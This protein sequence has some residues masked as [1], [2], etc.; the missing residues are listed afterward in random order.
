MQANISSHLCFFQISDLTLTNPLSSDG[1]C[2]SIVGFQ[3]RRPAVNRAGSWKALDSGDMEGEDIIST[4]NQSRKH[5]SN[6]RD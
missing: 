3:P 1:K 6:N 2:I 5:T 4:I